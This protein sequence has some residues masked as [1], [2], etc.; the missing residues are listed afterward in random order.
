MNKKIK[1]ILIIFIILNLIM[2]GVLTSLILLTNKQKEKEANEGSNNVT[3]QQIDEYHG[4]IY[5]KNIAKLMYSYKGNVDINY[6][7]E[8][9]YKL[10]NYLPDLS[11]I[12][13]NYSEEQLRQYFSQNQAQVRENTGITDFSTFRTLANKIKNINKNSK[14]KEATIDIPSY[15]DNGDYVEFLLTVIYQDGNEINFTVHLT[16]KYNKENSSIVFN[17]VEE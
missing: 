2:L 10:V 14:Y 1:V 4:R 5:P 15:K 3:A 11:T 8:M 16:N 7:Y 9:S 12:I 6:F 13:S 17:P